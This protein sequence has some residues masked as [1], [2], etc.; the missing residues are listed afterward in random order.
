L[1]HSTDWFVTLQTIAGTEP[2]VDYLLD[3]YDQ[4]DNLVLGVSDS[5]DGIY[6]PREVLLHN[7]HEIAG[8]I[9]WRDWKLI[10][11]SEATNETEIDT[12]MTKKCH[13]MWCINNELNESETAATIQCSVSGN[14][15]HPKSSNI[16]KYKEWNLFNI[17]DDPC[18]YNDLKDSEKEI[19]EKMLEMFQK[20]WNQQAPARFDMFPEN[21]DAADPAQF[22]GVWSPWHELTVHSPDVLAVEETVTVHSRRIDV[23]QLSLVPFVLLVI[24]GVSMLMLQAMTQCIKGRRNR[25][26]VEPQYGAV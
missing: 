16:S 14:Y 6:R 5:E 10:K 11:S 3:S 17:A 13:N 20:F 9:R 25:K 7:A 21:Y 1:M 22:N 2:S 23:L 19:Y 12:G 18:E 8:A 24:G 26:C 15:N 4:A